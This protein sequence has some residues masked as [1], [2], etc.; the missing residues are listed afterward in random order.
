MLAFSLYVICSQ[1]DR[2]NDERRNELGG[3]LVM[4]CRGP[5]EIAVRYNKYVVNGKLFRTLAFD[6]GRVS[7]N[8]GVCVPTVDGITY[9]EKLIE[10]IEVEYYD[11]T[12]YVLF[13]CKWADN[14]KGKG[15]KED[16]YGLTFVNFKNLV[17]KGEMITDEPYVLTS[18]V[19][20]V[21]YVEDERDRDWACAVK[22]KPRNVYDVGRGEGPHDVCE[23][24]HECEPMITTSPDCH[25]TGDDVDY[26]RVDVDPIKAYV[27]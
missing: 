14:T 27:I 20:Q 17:H 3:K 9:F 10:V 25:N 22:I 6:V 4:H 19:N 1:I 23:N 15:Y 11:R 5:R 24:H 26:V 16:K 12:R 13:K 18:Q 8:S 21:F 7:Q 2:A